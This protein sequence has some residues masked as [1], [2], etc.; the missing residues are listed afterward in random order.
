MPNPTHSRIEHNSLVK[1]AANLPNESS[2]SFQH[3]RTSSVT[4][5]S[6]TETYVPSRK[7]KMRYG[8][9][10]DMWLHRREREAGSKF[11][12]PVRIKGRKFWRLSEL[13]AYEQSLTAQT[14][15]A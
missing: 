5:Q 7:V 1:V 3:E 6:V 9:V 2:F 12:K 4:E 10:S 15:A 11:P 13:V 8:G 14:E